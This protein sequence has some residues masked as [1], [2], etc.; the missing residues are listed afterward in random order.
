ML[1]LALLTALVEDEEEAQDPLSVDKS[2]ISF[3]RIQSLVSLERTAEI[4]QMNNFTFLEFGRDQL[5][6]Q[7]CFYFKT[8]GEI[9]DFT[10]SLVREIGSS[11]CSATI[12]HILH[13]TGYPT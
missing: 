6:R 10:F 1:S 7:I 4:L 3:L 12:F 13:T 9:E 5:G 11:P 8:S 2:V